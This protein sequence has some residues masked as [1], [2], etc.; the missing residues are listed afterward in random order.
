MEEEYAPIH[1][2]YEDFNDP[3]YQFNE[4]ILSIT[5]NGNQSKVIISEFTNNKAEYL[6]FESITNQV[7]HAPNL[8]IDEAESI[9]YEEA[10]NESESTV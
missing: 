9:I 6:L 8:T 1:L 4:S 5:F 7:S 2:D 3:D 10:I